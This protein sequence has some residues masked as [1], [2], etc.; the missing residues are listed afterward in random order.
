MKLLVVAQTPPPLHGQSVMVQSMVE[1]L[2]SRNIGIVHVNLGLSR[3]HAD[4]GRA[5][6]GKLATALRA[7][8]LARRLGRREGC[9]ALYYVPAPGKR[10]A[11]WRDFIV[12]GL[13]RSACPRLVLH[14][15]ASG[16]GEWLSQNG[17]LR[18]LRLAQRRLGGAD[19]SIVL[20]EALRADA[21]RF[22]PR[23]IA[24][25]RNGIPDP[26]PGFQRSPRRDPAIRTAV[27]LGR[28]AEEKGV[29]D[30][31]EGVRLANQSA[32]DLP[33]WRLVFAG[34][35]PDFAT[36]ERIRQ[37]AHDSG[38]WVELPGFLDGPA[39]HELLARADALVFPTYYPAETQG[40]VVAEAL[41]HDLPVILTDWR[42][43]AEDLPEKHIHVVPLQSPPAIGAALHA[44]ARSEDPAGL[45][46]AHFL[47]RYA[48][49]P[50]LD[51][52]AALL[53]SIEPSQPG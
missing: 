24:V 36:E 26:C 29:F 42:S 1:G 23:Q 22:H 16:L 15:H 51:G 5:R 19:L 49:A 52:L 6:A 33:R 20:G 34:G 32:G 21:A 41:A 35:Y 12:L 39:K 38:G 13:A 48:Q 18:E 10:V 7:G 40:L 50:F 28:V 44:I 31:V 4:I 45:L 3:D 25:L 8:W 46:R 27:Y 47:R 9:D 43:V 14:W 30:A 2:P 17:T 37:L 11:L 53:R